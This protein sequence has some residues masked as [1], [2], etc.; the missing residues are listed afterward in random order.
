MLTEQITRLL[1]NH[2]NPKNLKMPWPLAKHQIISLLGTSISPNESQ[3][4]LITRIQDALK[5]LESEG[6]V[7]VGKRNLYC[8]A[9]PTVLA[10][11][12]EDLVTLLF[13]G[14]R[15]YLTLAH[16]VLDSQQNPQNPLILRPKNNHF[17]RI[18]YRLSQVGIS[19]LIISDSLDYLPNLQKPRKPLKS[20]LRSTWTE[21][22]FFLKNWQIQLYAP[23]DAPQ[24]DRWRNLSYEGIKNEDILRLPTGEY[25]WFQDQTFYEL[26]PDL[27]ILAM[28]YQDQQMGYP[29]KISWD[30]PAGRLK[31]KSI[32]LPSNYERWLWDISQPTGEEYR[33][34]NFESKNWSLVKEV[35]QR[36]G[37]KLV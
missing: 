24:K 13:R 35:F 10:K 11:N 20:E 14:D 33:T 2:R 7:V 15:A 37:T 19:L 32:Y 23:C 22:P 5:Q 18:K 12:R 27:A 28:F 17:N 25:I 3:D 31:L 4:N 36:L 16:K 8:M 6:E 26:E 21:D 30:E 9:L 1:S 29:L 34:R